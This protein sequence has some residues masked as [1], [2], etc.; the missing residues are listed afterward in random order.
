MLEIYKNT[1]VTIEEAD[2]YFNEK[3]GADFWADLDETSK[4]KALVT[5]SRQIDIQPFLGRKADPE[6]EMSFPRII[7]GKKYDVLNR[8][9]AAVCEQT[10][11]LFSNDYENTSNVK[12]ISLGAASITFAD[13]ANFELS[14]ETKLLLSGLLKT[15][16]DIEN[17]Y[18]EEKY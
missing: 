11:E 1:Y 12:S 4:E 13:N 17:T 6:Q 10:F 16:F 9:K 15:G 2:E 5:A 8:I 18:Y 7:R 14:S 3:L